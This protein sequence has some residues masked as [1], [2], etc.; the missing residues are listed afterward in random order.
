MISQHSLTSL[1]VIILAGLTSGV[2][3]ILSTLTLNK[4]KGVTAM[5]PLQVISSGVLGPIDHSYVLCWLDYFTY[6]L[7]FQ[8]TIY[9]ENGATDHYWIRRTTI[10]VM[11]VL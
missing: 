11:K 6:H 10:S 7:S 3:D 9:H 2:L 4:F 1:Q 5:R 8:L